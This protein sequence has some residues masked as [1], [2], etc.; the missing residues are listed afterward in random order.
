MAKLFGYKPNPAETEWILGDPDVPVWTLT[1]SDSSRIAK[2]NRD[3]NPVILFDALK[4]IHPTWRRGAQGIGD[5]VAWGFEL[6]CTIVT[7]V[8][9]YHKKKPWMWKGEYA[10]EP[11]Y[12]GSRVEARGRSQGGWSDGSYGGAAAKWLTKWGALRRLN[13]SL[14][15]GIAEHDLTKYDAKRAKDWGNWGCGGRPDSGKLDAVAKEFPVREAY[16]VTKYEDAVSAIENG[17]PIAVC[18]GQGLGQRNSDGFA[19]PRGSWAHCM[20][21]TGVRYDKPGLL[22]TNS[23]GNSWGT[24]N[25]FGPGLNDYWAEVRKCSAW[26]DARTVEGMLRQQDSYVICGVDGLEPRNIDWSLG[27]EISGR[28]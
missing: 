10:T 17:W 3:G 20:C 27:W 26:V 11:I 16:L 25:P 8:D 14:K 5:C 23:W 24:S 13:Y 4:A 7:A 1:P 18:S 6:A 12:G 9:I 2:Q 19:P 21:F 15:T 28:S 22:C